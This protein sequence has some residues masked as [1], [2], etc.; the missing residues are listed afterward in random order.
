MKIASQINL[1]LYFFPQYTRHHPNHRHHQP[2][3]PPNRT[4]SDIVPILT[5]G[6]AVN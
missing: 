6:G 2:H 4:H 3:Q 1:S 5:Y